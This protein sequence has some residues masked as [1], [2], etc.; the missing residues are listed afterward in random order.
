MK[1]EFLLHIE[2]RRS[3]P[4][5]CDPGPCES[6]VRALLNAAM[7]ANDHGKLRPWEFRVYSGPSREVLSVAYAAHE[8]STGDGDNDVKRAIKLPMRAP[9]I[10]CVSTLFKEGK[11]PLRDQE[12]SAAACCQLMTLSA[13]T[14]GYGSIWR[15]GKYAQSDI[16]KRHLGIRESDRIIGFIYIG[17]SVH[18]KERAAERDNQDRVFF[19][20]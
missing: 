8:L 9:T 19:Y 4:A 20:D 1:H 11:I 7:C 5:L 17:T 18:K 2:S 3:S 16:V 14:L 6:E 15:T 13:H 10:V 12:L